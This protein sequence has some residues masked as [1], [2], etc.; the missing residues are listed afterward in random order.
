MLKNSSISFF[1]FTYVKIY[2][3]VVLPEYYDLDK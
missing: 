1:E 3:G 2:L